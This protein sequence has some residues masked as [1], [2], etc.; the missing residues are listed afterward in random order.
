[1]RALPTMDLASQIERRLGRAVKGNKISG[2][3]AK[4]IQPVYALT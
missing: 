3:G 2:R 4:L 1:M